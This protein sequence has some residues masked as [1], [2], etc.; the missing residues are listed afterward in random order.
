MNS[1]R[2]V[3]FEFM[4]YLGGEVY[5]YKARLWLVIGRNDGFRVKKGRIL[6]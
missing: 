5:V 1:S 2:F 6:G 3:T 4:K